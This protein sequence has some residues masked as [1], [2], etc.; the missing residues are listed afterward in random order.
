MDILFQAGQLSGGNIRIA[1]LVSMLIVF[2]AV[3]IMVYRRMKKTEAASTNQAKTV[4]T[5]VKTNN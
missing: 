5:E 1:Q 2:V 3:G 4:T